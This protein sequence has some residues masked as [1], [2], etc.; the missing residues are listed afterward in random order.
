MS[1]NIKAQPTILN[2][3]KNM[4]SDFID[5]KKGE[6]GEK[7]ASS[8]GEEMDAK[9]YMSDT[10]EDGSQISPIQTFKVN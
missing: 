8:Q 6:N 1:E 10:D 2:H 3:V 7:G 4:L 9:V 5:G